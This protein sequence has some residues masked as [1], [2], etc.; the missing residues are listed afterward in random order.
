MRTYW[1]HQSEKW[2]AQIDT[3][4]SYGNG[5]AVARDLAHLDDALREALR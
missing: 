4:A 3:L 1:L 2:L 5:H